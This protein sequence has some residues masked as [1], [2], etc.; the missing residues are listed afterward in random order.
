MTE[1]ALTRTAA[2]PLQLHHEIEQFLYR[3]AELLDDW[4]FRDW[5]ALMAADV[6]YS[7]RTTVNA[8]T[9]DRRRSVQPP[10]TWIF[11]DT[12]AQLERRIA[13]LETG[14]AWAEEPPSRTRH[15]VTN[16]V[17]NATDEA[18]TFDVRLNYLLY[19]SQ[20]ERDE[21]IYAGKR[22]DRVR[23]ADNAAGWQI[24]RREITLDQATLNSHNLSVLF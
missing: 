6:H 21:T 18:D 22:C 7:M 14:M 19:R 5:L 2:V 24:C 10:T 23:R 8:Q 13:R 3:E 15:L 11:N 9:R 12:Y 17:V 20:K 1:A 16:V 4:R